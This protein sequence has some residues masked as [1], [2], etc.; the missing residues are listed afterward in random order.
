MSIETGIGE[1][2]RKEIANGLSK[3]LADTYFLYMKTHGF[4]WNV[5]GP[6]FKQ[7][8]DMFEEQYREQWEALDELAER[9]RAL[10]EYAPS[11]YDEFAALSSMSETKGVPG[12]QEMVKILKEGNEAVVKTARAAVP[13]AAEAGDEATVDLITERLTAH[14]K[15]AWMLRASLA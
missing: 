5:T 1:N 12:A 4:H 11:T 3:L 2:A 10:G 6:H 15:A 14:E 8:H 9:I 13:A 7:Y